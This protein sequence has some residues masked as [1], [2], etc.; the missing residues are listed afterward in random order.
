MSTFIY[1][2]KQEASLC[3]RHCLNNLLQG[4][5]F[6]EID[7]MQIA[8]QISKEEE[9]LIRQS[10]VSNTRDEDLSAWLRTEQNAHVDESGNFSL[11]VLERALNSLYGLTIIRWGS[12]ALNQKTYS[13]PEKLNAFILNYGNHWFSIIKVAGVWYDM[14][15]LSGCP[16]LEAQPKR[17]SDFYLQSYIQALQANKHSVFVVSGKLPEHLYQE[18]KL[19]AWYKP[20]DIMTLAA[21][22]EKKKK[23]M[24]GSSDDSKMDANLQA[25]IQ[26]SLGNDHSTFGTNNSVFGNSNSAFLSGSSEVRLAMAIEQSLQGERKK[27]ELEEKKKPTE[28]EPTEQE[29]TEQEDSSDEKEDALLAVKLSL[30]DELKADVPAD[31]PDRVEVI[32]QTPL[33]IKKRGFVKTDMIADVRLWATYETGVQAFKLTLPPNEIINDK[34]KLDSLGKKIRLNMKVEKENEDISL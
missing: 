8:E 20:S 15:S 18:D 3:A 30:E 25:A 28:Q 6:T 27:A 10:A 2:E 31:N 29:P 12:S 9:D 7:L 34:Q 5:K 17:I 22:D 11:P 1:H 13:E 19:G 33:G 26:A 16:Y 23:L 21:F 24:R 32:L 4:P 14:N